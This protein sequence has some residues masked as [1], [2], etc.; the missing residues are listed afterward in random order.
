[1]MKMKGS[2]NVVLINWAISNP[3]YLLS[4]IGIKTYL[5]TERHGGEEGFLYGEV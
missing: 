4:P 2:K 5:N 3:T 1:M